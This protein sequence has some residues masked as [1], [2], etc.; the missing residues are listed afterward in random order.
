MTPK[1]YLNLS[2]FLSIFY[3]IFPQP[4]S[5]TNPKFLF[6]LTALVNMGSHKES[7][8]M[9]DLFEVLDARCFNT[10]VDY[11]KCHDNFLRDVNGRLYLDAYS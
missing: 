6:F 7:D 8:I 1:A 5:R 2:T 11:E 4:H 3:A 10:V 9:T